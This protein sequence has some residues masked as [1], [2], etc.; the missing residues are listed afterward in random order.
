MFGNFSER[1]ILHIDGDAFFASCEQ[2]RDPR[3]RG[4]PVITGKERGIAA[5][6][7][8]E[9]KARGVTR[10]MSLFEI[11]KLCP[12]AVI[13]PSD[14][15]TYGLLSKRLFSIVR[16]YTPAVEEYGI[17]ECFADI[18]GLRR[19][20]RTSYSDIALKIKKNIDNELGFTFSVGLAPTKVLAK[21][22]SKWKKPSGFTVINSRDVDSYLVNWPVEKLWGIGLQTTAFLNKHGIF[23]S[24]DFK[25]KDMLWL[26]NNLAKPQIEI[27]QELHGQSAIGINT[28]AKTSY[29]SIQKFKT[30]T[31]PSS[32]RAFIFSQLSKNI[33]NVCMKARRYSLATD[34]FMIYLRTQNFHDVG[35]EFVLEQ[36]T[37]FPNEVISLAACIF[38][39]LFI[40]DRLYRTTG[41]V[42]LNLRDDNIIQPN[43]FRKNNIQKFLDLYQSFDSVRRKYGKHTLFLGSS[44]MANKFAQHLGS[45]G[46]I[47]IRHAEMF[48]GETSRKRLNIP[49]FMGEVT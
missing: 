37:S 49:M 30:F 44:F 36:P 25:D 39:K 8:Y 43:L 40:S 16:R 38:D 47:P 3:L 33:E 19:T 32:D 6:M 34:K 46:D 26:K 2:S 9:A 29:A 27:W 11:K 21:I 17:D 1:A 28:E 15:E 41:V 5:S 20:F 31:P 35:L 42:M 12:D 10:G 4:K 13:M 18:T 24:L 14:Y 48:K 7:S 45:R 23:S 22:G